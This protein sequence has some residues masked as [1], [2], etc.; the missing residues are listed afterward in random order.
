ML[1][2]LPAFALA[3]SF[4]QLSAGGA[5]PAH[6]V[7]KTHFVRQATSALGPS[8]IPAACQSICAPIESTITT[9]QALSCLCN[10]SVA[11]QI[12]VCANCFASA[13]GDD[14]ATIQQE[15]SLIDEYTNACAT[16]GE[17]VSVIQLSTGAVSGTGTGTG[18]PTSGSVSADAST[19]GTATATGAAAAAATSSSSSSAA[20]VG[21]AGG[22]AAGVWVVSGLGALFVLL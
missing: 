21:T 11:Q 8:S 2:A 17:S 5:P 9:C 7:K 1:L 19:T 16:S 3:V 10:D 22:G 4:A 15:Q 12:A 6:F 14:A 13:S 20:L 18:T